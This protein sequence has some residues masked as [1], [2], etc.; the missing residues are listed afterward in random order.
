MRVIFFWKCWKFDLDL[1]NVKIISQKV[2]CFSDK[3]VWIRCIKMSLLRREYLSW[4]VNV[5]TNSL[6]TLRVTKS[7]FFQLNYLHIGQWLWQRCCRW[8]W[9][10]VSVRL[11]C[12]LSRDPLKQD[13]LDIYLTTCLSVRHFGN[14]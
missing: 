12:C 9:I 7:D 14:T 5:L 4:A 10:S 2:F 3:C 6:K 8:G 11:P 1:K 13:F